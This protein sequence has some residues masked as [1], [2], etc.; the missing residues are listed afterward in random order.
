M[1]ATPKKRRPPEA[2]RK[3]RPPETVR[4]APKPPRRTAKSGPPPWRKALATFAETARGDPQA[5]RVVPP[6]GYTAVLTIA[7]SAI[8]AFLAVIALALS[9]SAARVASEWSDAL[10]RTSTIRISSDG[11]DPQTQVDAV[12]LIL[13]ETPGVGLARAIPEAERRALLEPWFGPDLPLDGLPI[14]QLVSVTEEGRG[15]DAEGL[16]LRLQAE[17]PGAVL[18]DHG[19]WRLPLAEAAAGLRTLGAVALLLIVAAT[20]AT[21]TLAASSA[22]AAN[23]EVIRVLRL[24]GARDVYIA[25]AFTRRFTLRA[26]AGAAIGTVVGALAAL[27]LPSGGAGFLGDVGF[28]GAGWLAPLL[29]P[30]VAALVGF[31]A[32]RAAAMRVLRALP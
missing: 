30:P 29:V 19:R 7:A 11:T 16:R 27:L 6:T 9:L 18:D 15:F 8:M 21:V 24:V 20:A 13:Q 28:S 31:A 4:A 10:A 12:L 22:L 1:S 32:T 26:L 23:A 3:G 14:P 17:V 2:P 5:D 25:R